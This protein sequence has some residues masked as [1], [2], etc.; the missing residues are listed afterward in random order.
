MEFSD[1]KLYDGKTVRAEIVDGLSE[2]LSYVN[3]SFLRKVGN[4]RGSPVYVNSI[5]EK[6]IVARS[7]R[8]D[9]VRKYSIKE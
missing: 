2:E 4:Y 1:V 3:K 6:I 9:I 8:C 7:L 5:S